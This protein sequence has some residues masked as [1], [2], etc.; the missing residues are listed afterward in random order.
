M[1]DTPIKNTP[2]DNL[3]SVQDEMLE[4][5]AGEEH[6]M[7]SPGEEEKL[8]T[9]GEQ[10]ADTLPEVQMVPTTPTVTP[11]EAP[12]APVEV[13]SA[14][15]TEDLFADL[16]VSPVENQ[17]APPIEAVVV[18]EV[19]TTAL[20]AES[21]PVAPITPAPIS[22]PHIDD[23]PSTAFYGQ[24][25]GVH[26]PSSHIGAFVALG[27]LFLSIV[28]ALVWYLTW[29]HAPWSADIAYTI[30]SEVPATY[31]ESIDQKR[32]DHAHDI[33]L[34][35]RAMSES[36]SS[37]C[38]AIRDTSLALECRESLL[39]LGF[40]QSGTVADCQ[41]LT[42]S[43]IRDRCQST[44]AQNTAL[45]AMDK[46]LCGGITTPTQQAYCREEIDARVLA[47]L[48]ETKTA[49]E[50]NCTSLETK[51]QEACLASIVRI[52]DN[53]IL[54]EAIST[55]TLELCKTL[56]TEDLR[57]TCFDAILMKRALVSGDKNNCDYLHDETKKATCL[58]RTTIQD[59]NEIFKKA[60][61]EKNLSSC[62]SIGNATLKDRCHDS[63]TLLLIRDTGD[64]T[65]CDTLTNTGTIASCKKMT[66]TAQ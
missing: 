20:A 59:D 38:M 29:D 22:A 61:I 10:L 14:S 4:L 9:S 15:V 8:L 11:E 49:T 48:I 17:V 37:L 45:S 16:P 53:T 21:L 18:P 19:I 25:H 52:D 63:V 7:I 40:T 33:E 36:D 13:E 12:V 64:A 1:S 42:L 54:Q 66:P 23:C 55:D 62:Q 2:E 41:I 60:I 35:N 50:A 6:L 51:H 32:D 27:V 44:I 46:T 30:S 58:A 43:D 57:Y 26:A 3:L 28:G 24:E 31:Q 65:L 34:M 39:S 47:N 56:S 5:T